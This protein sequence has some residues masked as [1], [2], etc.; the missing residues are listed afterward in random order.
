MM[1]LNGIVSSSQ[2]LISTIPL[3]NSYTNVDCVPSLDYSVGM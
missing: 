3:Q 2:T 1:Y